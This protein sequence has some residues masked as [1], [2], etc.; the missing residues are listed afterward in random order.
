VAALHKHLG[1]ALSKH[2][3]REQ[4]HLAKLKRD[5]ETAAAAAATAAAAAAAGKVTP[6]AT[7]APPGGKPT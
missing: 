3:A 7:P 5:R 2:Q 6:G 1:A 4:A